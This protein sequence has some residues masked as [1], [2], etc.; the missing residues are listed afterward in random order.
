M[1]FAEVYIAL[2]GKSSEQLV[3]LL[4][5]NRMRMRNKGGTKFRIGRQTVVICMIGLTMTFLN[6][7][8]ELIFSLKS[9]SSS[10]SPD[11]TNDGQS[12]H[13]GQS[14]YGHKNSEW[15]LKDNKKCAINFFGLPRSFESLVLPSLVKNV[16]ATNPHCDYFVHY[17]NLTEEAKGRSTKTGGF[18]HAEQILLLRQAVHRVNPQAVVQFAVTIEDQFWMQYND[19]LQRIHDTKDDEDRYLYFP[20][21]AK[22]YT[23]PTTVDNIVKMW[24]S[25]QSVWN[26]MDSHGVSRQGKLN[27]VDDAPYYS[28][29]AMLRSDIVYITPVRIWEIAKTLTKKGTT[30]QSTVLIRDTENQVAVIPAF[31]RYPVNDR[32]IYGPYHAV[33]QWALYR[34]ENLDAHVKWMLQHD[35]GFGMHSERFIN[36]SILPRI[37]GLGYGL[38]QHT[39]M[40]FLRARVDE[41]IWV[42]DCSMDQMDTDVSLLNNV[43]GLDEK[44][45]R[46]G[47]KAPS[48]TVVQAVKQRVERVLGRPCFPGNTSRVRRFVLAL[49]C[50]KQPP[51]TSAV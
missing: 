8:L 30:N 41:S 51:G 18:V 23:Y 21:K 45:I 28:R 12:Q 39:S 16:I 42:T 35:P 38:W 17:Y 14:T 9:S 31:A 37:K 48:P 22:T 7:Q 2:L 29:V 15:I 6:I 24:Y 11:R 46:E 33:Q 26:L 4:L 40:C 1:K 32:I 34:F 50:G 44:T 13:L 43:F 49:H 5:D 3:L 19:L 27:H 36:N 47:R 10:S 25:I 20:W